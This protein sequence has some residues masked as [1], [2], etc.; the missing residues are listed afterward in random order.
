M[1]VVAKAWKVGSRSISK[2]CRLV[3]IAASPVAPDPANGSSTS[4][5][6]FVL[7]RISL[8]ISST[9][10]SVGWI[11]FEPATSGQAIPLVISASDKKLNVSGP[12]LS[13]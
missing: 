3:R 1:R 12:G 11:R 2:A 9:G 5:P 10:F 7:T 8:S 13:A 6:G 4:S